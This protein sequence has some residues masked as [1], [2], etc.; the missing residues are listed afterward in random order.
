MKPSFFE[1][2][3]Q[4]NWTLG[5]CATITENMVSVSVLGFEKFAS[6]VWKIGT[7]RNLRK[8][9]SATACRA[10][11]RAESF[12]GLQKV[13]QIFCVPGPTT[14]WTYP[15]SDEDILMKELKRRKIFLRKMK[16]CI[17]GRNAKASYFMTEFLIVQKISYILASLGEEE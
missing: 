16:K 17:F 7:S 10:W 4:R 8:K 11:A 13:L 9:S 2:F 3:F 15:V 12:N 1:N 5:S 14:L 6:Q